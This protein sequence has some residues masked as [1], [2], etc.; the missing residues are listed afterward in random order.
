MADVLEQA[1]DL[2]DVRQGLRAVAE[3]RRLTET[4]EKQQVEAAL[5][6]GWTWGD[7]AAELGVT[8]QA[9][10]RKHRGRIPP[11]LAPGRGQRRPKDVR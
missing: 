8:R 6:Q 11:D 4:L 9:V 7:I 10:H 1:T 3:L 2:T 5:R